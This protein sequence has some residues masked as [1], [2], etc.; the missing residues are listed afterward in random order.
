[1]YHISHILNLSAP[2][3]EIL[4]IIYD[5]PHSGHIVPIQ[6]HEAVS[7]FDIKSSHDSFVDLLFEHAPLHHGFFLK[8]LPSRTYLDLNRASDDL[9]ACLLARD[10]RT[11]IISNP[12]VKSHAGH[13]L[14]WRKTV[15]GKNLYAD[16]LTKDDIHAR[17]EN[18]WQPYHHHLS[19]LY[20]RLKNQ[21]GF[22]LH[23]NCHSMPSKA[24]KGLDVDIV[25]GNSNGMSASNDLMIFLKQAFE[26]QGLKVAMNTPYSGAYLIENYSDPKNH[27]HAIQIEINR[28]LYLDE[29]TVQCNHNFLNLKQTLKKIMSE[30]ANYAQNEL[31]KN[32]RIYHYDRRQSYQAAE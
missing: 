27:L 17:I 29:D 9:D 28:A 21:F 6:F 10:E 8:A 31:N 20:Q 1:M 18:Y 11:H 7:R 2:S 26:R 19:K 14:I 23:L 30:I 12:T 32:Q 5:S 13:G 16:F 25:L 24:V 4:P 15:T 22:V 3:G